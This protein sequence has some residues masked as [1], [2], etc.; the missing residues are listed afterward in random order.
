MKLKQDHVEGDGLEKSKETLKGIK[1]LQAENS[2][3]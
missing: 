3:K 2:E 1:I